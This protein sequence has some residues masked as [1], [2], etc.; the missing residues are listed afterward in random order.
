MHEIPPD[1]NKF[2]PVE[3]RFLSQTQFFMMFMRILP[4]NASAGVNRAT[5]SFLGVDARRLPV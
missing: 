3:H 4:E 1:A 5:V 2:E